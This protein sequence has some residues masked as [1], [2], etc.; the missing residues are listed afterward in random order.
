MTAL[1]LSGG[2]L[3]AITAIGVLE[4]LTELNI[5]V[6]LVVG[7]SAGALVGALYASGLSPERLGYLAKSVSKRYFRVSWSRLAWQLLGHR[8]L[9]VSLTRIDPLFSLT[10]H[11][12]RERSFVTTVVPLWVT[13]TD[14]VERQTVVF[15]PSGA[16]FDGH[17]AE[18][19]AIARIPRTV[20]LATAVRASTAVPGLFFPVLMDGRVLVDGGIGD[21]FPVDVAVLAGADRVIGV[22]IDEPTPWL[23]PKISAPNLLYQSLATMIRQMSMVR[24]A[25]VAGQVAQVVLRIPMEVGM[26]GFGRIPHLIRLGYARAMAEREALSVLVA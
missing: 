17:L 22:W 25:V 10:D 13:A 1:V 26:T 24:A 6:D 12:L 3:S 4:A 16:P 18:L 8:K 19:L 20:D 14:L 15:G 9:P 2:G 11:W 23:D 21:D 5:S 7:S